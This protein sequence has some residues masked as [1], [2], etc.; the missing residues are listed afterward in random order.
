[1]IKLLDHTNTAISENI[2]KVWQT[3]YAVEAAILKATNFPP[4]KRT[5]ENFTLSKTNFL[6]F[7]EESELVAV[8]EIKDEEDFVHVQSLVV[9]PSHFRKGIAQKLLDHVFMHFPSPLFMVE[10]GA[11]NEPGISLYE[12]NGFVEVKQW[13]TENAI[14]KIR[15]EKTIN[16]K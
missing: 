2:W 11:A 15:L 9:H 1:M 14:R 7:W 10:T 5:I 3:S 12:K 16:I 4:L 13:D 8:T 6:G